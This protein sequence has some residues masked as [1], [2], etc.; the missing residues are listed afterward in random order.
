M[1]NEKGQ[2]GSEWDWRDARHA[3]PQ[4]VMSWIAHGGRIRLEEPTPKSE[5]LRLQR[6]FDEVKLANLN[7]HIERYRRLQLELHFRTLKL[8]G[9]V[10]RR[11]RARKIRRNDI[12]TRID[13]ALRR[14]LPPVPYL[15]TGEL[16]FITRRA[17]QALDALGIKTLAELL[18]HPRPWYAARIS[19]CH[20]S[21]IER[22]LLPRHLKLPS[23]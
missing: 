13:R 1:A 16:R 21:M 4:S 7:K 23:A 17:R 6:Y 11:A 15:P 22:A 14:R 5:L 9:E 20:V 12:H 18:A 3:D 8:K 10:I 2:E 19:A